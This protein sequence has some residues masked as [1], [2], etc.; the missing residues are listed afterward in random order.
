MAYNTVGGVVN[1]AIELAQLD[2]GFLPLARQYYNLILNNQV[3]KF[4]WPYYRTQNSDVLFIAGQKAYDLPDRY[5]RSDTCFLVDS[6]GNTFPIVIR[7]KYQFDLLAYNQFSGDPVMAYIDMHAKQIVFNSTPTAPRYWR[8]TY[9]RQ[10]D[11]IDESGGNDSDE[12]DFQAPLALIY[13][14]TAMLMDYTDDERAS[15]FMAKAEKEIHD[16]KMDSFDEDNNSIVELGPNYKQGTRP[17]RGGASGFGF[18]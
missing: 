4:D 2:S 12:I 1:R 18:F 7:S 8:L 9:F 16:N 5:T 10:P 6:Y 15:N 13:L 14:I 3:T 17:I 11:Q